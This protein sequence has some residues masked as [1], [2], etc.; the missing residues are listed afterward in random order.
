MHMVN[1]DAKGFEK[2]IFEAVLHKIN[3]QGFILLSKFKF[4]VVFNMMQNTGCYILKHPNGTL[5]T[6][7]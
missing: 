3:S 7:V 6:Y 1:F 5:T 2:Y 4:L